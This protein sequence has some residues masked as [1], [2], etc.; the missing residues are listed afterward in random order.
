MK[1][2]IDASRANRLMRTGTEWYSFYLIKE[3][4]KLDKENKYILY[5]DKKPVDD[6]K[7]LIKGSKN[8]KLK[9][10]KWP[11]SNFWTIGRLSLEMLFRSPDV[12]FVPA[13]SLPFFCP[14]KT[15]T[16]IHDIAFIREDKVYR[17]IKMR[18][19]Y[20]IF[21]KFISLLIKLFTLGKHEANSLD[22]LDF[23][24][25]RSLKVAKKIIAVSEFT[26]SELLNC[27]K[28]AKEDKIEVIHNGYNSQLYRPINNK[29]KEEEVLL[30]Y[31]LKKPYYLYVGR[32]EK[33]KN[34]P[35]LL[36]AFS[37]LKEEYPNWPLR[38]ALVGSA[39]FGYDEVKYVIEDYNLSS[40]VDM[41]G[42][43]AEEDM[44]YVY[45]AALAFIFPTRHEGFGIPVIEAMACNTATAVSDL[46]VLREVAKEASLFFDYNE[47]EKIAMTL[48]D[49]Y[50]DEDLRKDLQTK[51][52]KRVENFSWEKSAKKTLDLILS[53]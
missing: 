45:N 23:S 4:I 52:L 14:K 36:E 6:L 22:Y 44:P 38:L 7:E 24:T 1:I 47:P 33:K 18:T 13:H 26:K 35:Y 9:V 8:F 21:S 11:W 31:G 25:K 53:L 41:P 28:T 19:N 20:S 15:L 2:G 46:E 12:L 51:G 43:I 10:L 39:S 27:Y 30:K 17:P 16:T 50:K 5:L 32:L 34:T 37:L 29:K 42:W 3:L 49:L 40:Q 48:I